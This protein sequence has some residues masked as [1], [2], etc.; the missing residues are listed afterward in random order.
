M[1]KE[2]A[3]KSKTKT[4]E[5]SLS[6]LCTVNSTEVHEN[7]EPGSLAYVTAD[8]SAHSVKA[9][10]S[11]G[12]TVNSTE[13]GGVQPI[14]SKSTVQRQARYEEFSRAISTADNPVDP[15]PENLEAWLE[16]AYPKDVNGVSIRHQIDMTM[17]E[18]REWV[19]KLMKGEVCEL[20]YSAFNMA[21]K[22]EPPPWAEKMK[23][24]VNEKA[25]IP[26]AG[27]RIRCPVHMREHLLEFH[28]KLYERMFIQPATDCESYAPVLIIR[29]PDTAVTSVLGVTFDCGDFYT[30]R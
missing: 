17:P 5:D 21:P 10:S 7:S 18:H 19:E 8:L 28:T 20:A 23:L 24:K 29:K 9:D 4:Q 12:K 30:R 3:W 16:A 22:F 1:C 14:P 2:S 25:G 6:F 13:A 26:K 11:A 15:T 27:A